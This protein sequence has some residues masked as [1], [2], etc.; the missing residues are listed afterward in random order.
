MPPQKETHRAV[1]PVR[2]LVNGIHANSGGAV[3]YLNNILP[4]LAADPDVDVHLCVREGHSMSPAELPDRVTRHVINVSPN[5][6]SVLIREQIDIPRLARR[7]GADVVFS[8][9][10]YGPILAPGLVILLRNALAVGTLERRPRQKVYWL[11]HYLATIISLLVCRRSIAVSDYARRMIPF[12]FSRKALRSAVIPHGVNPIFS[13]RTNDDD[14]IRT[15]GYLLAVSDVYIQKNYQTLISAFAI[16]RQRYPTL[17]LKI[18]G[19]WLD[20]DYL[21]Q[22][23]NL[24]EKN[25]VGDVV[26]FLGKRS[27]QELVTLYRDCRVFVFPSFVETFGHPLVEAMASGAAIASSNVA[28]MPEVL[29]DAALYFDP[30]DAGGMADTVSRILDDPGLCREMKNRASV[31]IRK[32]SWTTTAQHTLRIIKEAAHP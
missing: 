32:Y 13:P 4:L 11:F 28:A 27:Q 1:A 14:E 3:T 16:L 26:E 12:P 23:R 24:A 8:P 29:E 30:S 9:A 17:R 15:G 19:S 10:N 2:V 20:Q 18:A 22:L 5:L 31:R 7:I 21:A 25:N 6:L